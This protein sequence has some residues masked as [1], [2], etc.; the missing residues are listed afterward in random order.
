MN[1][2]PISLLNCLGKVFEKIILSRLS[3]FTESN[4]ILR[5]E[6]FGFRRELSTTQQ[7]K[8]IVNL[9]KLYKS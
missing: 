6:Q 8:R 4:S 5:K 9:V 1:Y 7:I 2:P 3:K